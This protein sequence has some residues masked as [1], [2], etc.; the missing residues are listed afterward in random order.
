MRE[1]QSPAPL[2]AALWRSAGKNMFAPT[3][4]DALRCQQALGSYHLIRQG[5]RLAHG[6]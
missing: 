1:I 4:R 5:A 3:E 2:L 6:R